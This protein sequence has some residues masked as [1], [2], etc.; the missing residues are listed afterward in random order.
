MNSFSLSTRCKH[1]F[2]FSPFVVASVAKHWS[3]NVLVALTWSW[4]CHV[5]YLISTKEMYA[6]FVGADGDERVV[7]KQKDVFALFLGV[8]CV[9]MFWRIIC[10]STKSCGSVCWQAPCHRNGTSGSG[11]R[12]SCEY[13]AVWD[14]MKVR[15]CKRFCAPST[16]NF[17][18][19]V[20]LQ[21][22]FKVSQAWAQLRVAPE[23][24]QG[25][26]GNVWDGNGCTTWSGPSF[27]QP[28][29][30]SSFAWQ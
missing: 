10:T 23:V 14:S 1:R 19:G 5:V 29:T 12:Q 15:I 27:V 16:S 7:A 4:A 25:V 17:S 24:V 3:K 13:L 28:I 8:L 22:V 2:F 9:M 20:A 30:P 6:A 21:W 11:N 18:Q 26:G